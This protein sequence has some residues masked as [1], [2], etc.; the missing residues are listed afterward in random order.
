VPGTEIIVMKLRRRSF[1]STVPGIYGNIVTLRIYSMLWNSLHK[2][3]YDV[4]NA[5][6]ALHV[7]RTAVALLELILVVGIAFGDNDPF[8]G[9]P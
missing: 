9:P 5:Q 2:P 6:L 3:S 8:S 4:H 7:S 1:C